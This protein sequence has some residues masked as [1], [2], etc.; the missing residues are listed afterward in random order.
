MLVGKLHAKAVLTEVPLAGLVP[1]SKAA[2]K[3]KVPAIIVLHLI[4]GGF[5]DRVVRFAGQEGIGALLVDPE[6]VKRKKQCVTVGLSSADAFSPLKIA[7]EVGWRLVDQYQA[8]IGLTVMEIF[9]P[10]RSH[11]IRRF[12]PDS[13]GRF[14]A[15]F[16]TPARLAE[17]HDLQIGEVVGRLKRS[18]ARPVISKAEIGMDFYRV[19]ALKRDLFL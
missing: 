10:D 11:A 14:S 6:E 17:Q 9:G 16:T 12:D 7:K 19:S 5:L 13:V 1:I 2:E 8:I 4:L 15:T 3:A 18:G